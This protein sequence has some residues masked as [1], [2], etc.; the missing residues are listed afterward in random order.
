MN[1][2]WLIDGYNLLHGLARFESKKAISRE[3]LFFALAGFSSDHE[4][5]VL[6]VLDG[7]GNEAEFSAF[8]TTHFKIRYSQKVSADALIEKALHDHPAKA[9]VCV[10]TEDR[11]IRQMA[12][13]FGARVMESR[14]FYELLKRENKDKNGLLFKETVK[15]HG[16]NRPFDKKLKDKG[17]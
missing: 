4:R 9:S 8:M 3:A 2:V 10:V 7:K 5:E 17:L 6:M 11:A 12:R 1:E 14:E 16:F 15:G 13:G